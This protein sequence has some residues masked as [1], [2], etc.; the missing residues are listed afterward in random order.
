[1]V[2]AEGGN[3]GT[4]QAPWHKAG[5]VILALQNQVFV[6]KPSGLEER[7]RAGTLWT[8]PRTKAHLSLQGIF[9]S[10][11]RQGLNLEFFLVPKIE[12]PNQPLFWSSE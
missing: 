12:P 8:D 7:F 3:L 2:V 10:E 9:S 11:K 6:N 5:R 1:M 4:A